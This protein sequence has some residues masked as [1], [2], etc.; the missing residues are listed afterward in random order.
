MNKHFLILL[1]SI[2]IS[3]TANPLR[4][5]VRVS[6]YTTG[7]TLIPIGVAISGFGSVELSSSFD[8]ENE[9]S[10]KFSLGADTL[11]KEVAFSPKTFASGVTASTAGVAIA[12]AGLK[13]IRMACK[14]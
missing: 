4:Y 7:S 8:P 13:L 3:L 11:D 6:Q 1:I 5:L 12:H 10:R 14:K 2:S 9:R